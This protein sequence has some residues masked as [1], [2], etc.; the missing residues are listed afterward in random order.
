MK[1]RTTVALILIISET[2]ESPSSVFPQ[3]ASID[4]EAEPVVEP[5]PLAKCGAVAGER[6][7]AGTR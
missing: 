6:R 1:T 7:K 2:R 3:P 5:R 4:V